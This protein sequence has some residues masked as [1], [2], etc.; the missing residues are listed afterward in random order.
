[1]RINDNPFKKDG[2]PTRRKFRVYCEV[3][4]CENYLI[5]KWGGGYAR[6]RTEIGTFDWRNESWNCE[7]HKD[8]KKV[9]WINDDFVDRIGSTQ[10][11][12]VEMFRDID[13]DM[14]MKD[15][16]EFDE[17]YDLVLVDYGFLGG[18]DWRDQ[19]E[20][21]RIEVLRKYHLAGI[22]TFWTGGLAERYPVEC[23]QD[24][25]RLK[26]LHKIKSWNLRDLTHY[27]SQYLNGED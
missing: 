16:F 9:L 22:P 20:R 2:N 17:K 4:S 21:D 3:G 15:V 13:V 1:M 26:F 11:L 27:V 24:F 18:Q 10:G 23:K 14:D 25:P 19:K 5:G 6:V 8:R 7:E 12:Y